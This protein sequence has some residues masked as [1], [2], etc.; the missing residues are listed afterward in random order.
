MDDEELIEALQQ[1]P[2]ILRALVNTMNTRFEIMAMLADPD[3]EPGFLIAWPANASEEKQAA[4]RQLV[5]F[6]AGLLMKIFSDD[7][8]RGHDHSDDPLMVAVSNR[9]YGSAN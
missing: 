7:L 6:V 1:H 5:R 8:D 4:A 2:D 3:I 9:V